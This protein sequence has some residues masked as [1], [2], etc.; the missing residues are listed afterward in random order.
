[1]S[2]TQ[3]GTRPPLRVLLSM[4]VVYDMNHMTTR[5]AR[6]FDPPIELPLILCEIIVHPI[7]MKMS[8]NIH[9]FDW[10]ILLPPG[11]VSQNDSLFKNILSNQKMI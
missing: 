11:P 3:D 1:M 10:M 2:D 7:I 5:H 8:D 4:Y 9:Q 6:F